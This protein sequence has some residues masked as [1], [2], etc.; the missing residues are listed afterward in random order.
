MKYLNLSE[1]DF[2]RNYLMGMT[3][4]KTLIVIGENITNWNLSQVYLTHCATLLTF[5]SLLVCG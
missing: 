4:A 3:G 5:E 2:E 1:I